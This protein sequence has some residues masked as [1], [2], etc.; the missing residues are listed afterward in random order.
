MTPNGGSHQLQLSCSLV[1]GVVPRNVPQPSS[2][3]VATT[4]EATTAESTTADSTRAES[5]MATS[6]TTVMYSPGYFIEHD[7]TKRQRL[8]LVAS[9][10]VTALL[11]TY[12]T[13]IRPGM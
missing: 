12:V 11:V 2:G 4:S 6:A 1:G 5:V 7:L 9:V 13:G 3:S 8:L 10:F